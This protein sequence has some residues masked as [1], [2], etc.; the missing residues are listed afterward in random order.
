M[1]DRRAVLQEP[2]ISPY[3]SGIAP[4][5]IPVLEVAPPLLQERKQEDEFPLKQHWLSD[6]RVYSNQTVLHD[7]SDEVLPD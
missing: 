7:N 1:D 6:H 2:P 4:H 5:R 3:Y